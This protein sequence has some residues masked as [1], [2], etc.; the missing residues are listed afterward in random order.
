M[1]NF[2][3]F[4]IEFEDINSI[5][6]SRGYKFDEET[7]LDSFSKLN[8]LLNNLIEMIEKYDFHEST[9]SKLAVLYLKQKVESLDIPIY[10]IDNKLVESSVISL[11]IST[12]MCFIMVKYLNDKLKKETPK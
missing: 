3:R 12:A 4:K 6:F 5:A 1:I 7:K 8:T 2:D 9:W 11:A 10:D